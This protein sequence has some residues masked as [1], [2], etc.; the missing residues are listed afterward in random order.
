M[1]TATK[2][3]MLDS[4]D[5]LNTDGDD[6]SDATAEPSSRPQPFAGIMFY[7]H[8]EWAGWTRSKVQRAI[9]RHGGK[10]SKTPA[11]D[12]N[13]ITHLILGGQLWS[14]QGTGLPDKTVQAVV[15]ANEAN[16]TAEDPD[17][18]R[19]WLLPLEWLEGSIAAAVKLPE[20]A[21]DFERQQDQEERQFAREQQEEL[22][23]ISS[24]S[25]SPRKMRKKND[26]TAE[27]TSDLGGC[28]APD[29]ADAAS[30]P[31]EE[32]PEEDRDDIEGL[33]RDIAL[34]VANDFEKLEIAGGGGAAGKQPVDENRQREV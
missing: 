27:V 10:I 28:D 2:R 6:D 9:E 11:F 8:G 15:A 33:A 22:Q 34:Q 23:Q 14:R 7:V 4:D 24:R 5:E 3:L 31:S 30:G 12:K 20:A 21:Y 25:R 1:P 26:G 18:K 32:S 29:K 16:Q 17:H 19:I 13:V